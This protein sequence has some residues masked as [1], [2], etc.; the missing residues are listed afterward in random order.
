MRKTFAILLIILLPTLTIAQANQT[1]PNRPIVFRHVTLIDMTSEQPKSDM[2]VVVKGNR[3]AEIG[4]NVRV[5]KNA[6]VIDATG[7]FLIPGLWDNYTFTLDAVRNN[8]PFFELLIAHGVTGV[9][10]AGTGM[11]LREIAKLRNEI[12]AGKI[13]APRLFYAGTVINGE[14]DKRESN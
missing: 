10:D 4:T 9:R 1:V 6:E 14:G 5:P 8:F 11:D 3:I 13:L 7:N 12:N 2:T